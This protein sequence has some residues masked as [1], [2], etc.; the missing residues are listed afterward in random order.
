M[1]RTTR[2][3][4]FSLPP[5][6]AE[7]LDEVMQGQGRVAERVPG[8][9]G[10]PLHRG[11]RVAAT[12]PVRRGP[13]PGSEASDP[14]M[15]PIWWRSTVPRRASPDHESGPGH[16]RD[17][18]RPELPRQRAMLFELALR[19]RFEFCLSRFILEAAAG[20]L[21]RKSSV[22][23]RNARPRRSGSLRTPPSSSNPHGCRRRSRGGH[24]DNR[25]LEC[26][27][28]GRA[29][30]PVTG[31]RRHL[32]PIGEHQ[33]TRIVNAPRFLSALGLVG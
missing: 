17:H 22:G 8:G 2:T 30:Y 1:P 21:V 20:V 9:G 12:A 7:R 5:E 15:W 16:Q 14:R 31:E 4:T 19:G 26:A 25:V 23:T 33:G 24:A 18:L 3:I 28:A 32:L 29:D 27:V 11:V 13:G 6:M 10:T